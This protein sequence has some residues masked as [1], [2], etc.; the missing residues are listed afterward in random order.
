MG[1]CKGDS[2][3]ILVFT[4]VINYVHCEIGAFSI[5]GALLWLLL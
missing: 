1:A 5:S 4:I 3:L 2:A